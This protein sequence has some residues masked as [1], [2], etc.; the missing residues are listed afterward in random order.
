[1]EGADSSLHKHEEQ[2]SRSAS[3]VVGETVA[4]SHQS[5]TLGG[6][7]SVG[8]SPM[9]LVTAETVPERA[10]PIEA[11]CSRTAWKICLVVVASNRASPSVRSIARARMGFSWMDSLR[12]T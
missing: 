8:P 4:A 9:A 2:R 6:G 3:R 10:A 5:I 12:V 7:G 1:M 11:A